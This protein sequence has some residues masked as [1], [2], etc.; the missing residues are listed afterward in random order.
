MGNVSKE[1]LQALAVLTDA[2]FLRTETRNHEFRHIS[3]RTHGNGWR[4]GRRCQK[5]KQWAMGDNPGETA[6]EH[7]PEA[8]Y[9]FVSNW[10]PQVDLN[11]KEEE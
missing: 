6:D 2:G 4:A 8:K 5:C 11:K 10:Y 3:T 1:V 9:R 7:C